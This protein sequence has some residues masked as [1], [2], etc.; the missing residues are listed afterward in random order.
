MDALIDRT[1][2]AVPAPAFRLIYG[3]KD[4]TSDVSPYCERVTFIDQLS[5]ESDEL[6]VELDDTA[7][8]WIGPW[9]PG[10]GDRLTLEMGYAGAPLLPCGV[11]EI[12]EIDFRR[13]PTTLS[14][15]ALGAGV[16]KPIR[17][18]ASRAF[19]D[20]T[21]AQIAER[22]ARKN[23]LTVVGDIRSVR[24]DRVTQYH[25]RDLQFL[26][27]L[28]REYGYAF[29]VKGDRLV[30]TALAALQGPS[31]VRTLAPGDLSGISIKDKI[32]GVYVA[33]RNRYHDPK[34]R[35]LVTDTSENR[36]ST[37][38]D[39]LELSRRSTNRD[40]AKARTE[41]AILDS[42]ADRTTATLTLPGDPVLVAG[43][44][45]ELTGMGKLSGIYL[46]TTA[47]HS[48]E[49]NAGYVTALDLRRVKESV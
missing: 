14:I 42:N 11:F 28:A 8:R 34:R 48:I 43:N 32:R 31:V 39:T 38:A 36:G 12:D 49:R 24:I 35:R 4:I 27:R 20:M 33:A 37:S 40:T 29:K 7:E 30:F 13:P 1:T 2:A 10:K 41:A 26:D 5:G 25:E 17:T 19:E 23:G 47:R 22:I 9:Y 3:Q 16:S 44:G 15:R 18:R 45:V 21:L 6:E 46:I